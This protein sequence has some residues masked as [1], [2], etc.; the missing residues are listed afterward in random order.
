[1]EF[2]YSLPS[3][4]NGDELPL[5]RAWCNN[6]SL[7]IMSTNYS[8][9]YELDVKHVPTLLKVIQM[10]GLEQFMEM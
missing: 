6:K 5:V 1:M 7:E 9:N 10:E 4:A 3:R 2:I 8:R